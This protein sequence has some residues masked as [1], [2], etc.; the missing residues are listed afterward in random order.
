MTTRR[1]SMPPVTKAGGQQFRKNVEFVGTKES[2]D[3]ELEAVGVVMVPDKADLQHDFVREDTIRD[4]ASQFETFIDADEADGGVMHAAWPSDWM[5]LVGNEVLEEE[6]AINGE[7]VE[8]G[9][10]VQNWGIND[11]DLARLIE[12]E[13]LSGYSIGAIDV[14]WNGP[15]EP[16]D[17]DDVKV[18]DDLPDDALVWELVSGIIREVSA[19][20]IP[21]VPDAEILEAKSLEKRL[22]D[23]IG[24]RDAF[25]EE[26]ME[27]GHS[28]GDAERLWDIL[29]RAIE[30]DGAATPGK[31]AGLV[32]RIGRAALEAVPGVMPAATRAATS[33]AHSSK[34]GQTLSAANRADEKAVMDAAA[35]I[36]QDAGVET[37]FTRFTDRED[38]PF[39]LD[40]HEARSFDTDDGEE[41]EGSNP[42]D[43]ETEAQADKDDPDGETSAAASPDAG[44]TM[45]DD[46]TENGGDKSLAER[47]AEQIEELT[48][49]VDELTQALTGDGGDGGSET[50][51]VE[52]D[53]K[54]YEVTRDEIDS[55]F[56]ED[57]GK[58]ADD[59]DV[60][61][62]IKELEQ[63]IERMRQQSGTSQQLDANGSDG[64]DDEG[65]LKAL[66]AT[67]S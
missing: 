43:P 2:D 59:D 33:T 63:R 1:D 40:D 44:D 15:F 56:D 47:N 35:S 51:R 17:V 14:S 39:T 29:N 8:A 19:V 42:F 11:A 24:N 22:A 49:S 31:S 45:T 65:G 23:H 46:D 3:Y 54:T 41:D 21:A 16:D 13:V 18:P 67:L 25:I 4:F 48:E 34:E 38:D 60:E 66:E 64:G 12:D 55:W 27:R 50:A 37:N 28:E 7:E 36:L 62:R 52:I 9:A 26:A 53:G 32:E 30:V 61:G 5:E 10:W 57:E 20:D 58:S 6:T